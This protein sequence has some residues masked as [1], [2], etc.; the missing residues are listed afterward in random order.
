MDLP[1]SD[2][3]TGATGIIRMSG[4]YVCE[5]TTVHVVLNVVIR[6]ERLDHGCLDLRNA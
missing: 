5:K 4:G 6:G 1:E 3:Y 2:Q